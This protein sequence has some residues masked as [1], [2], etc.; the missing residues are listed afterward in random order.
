M[1]GTNNATKMK[2]NAILGILCAI[3][4][5]LVSIYHLLWYNRPGDLFCAV[6]STG[7]VWPLLDLY[8]ASKQE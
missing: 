6:A 4:L 5:V 1:A 8:K 7:M 3:S 2:V